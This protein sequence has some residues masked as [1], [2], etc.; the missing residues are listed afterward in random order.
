MDEDGGLPTTDE[1]LA[2][3]EKLK[4]LDDETVKIVS[5]ITGAPSAESFRE[6]FP[7]LSVEDLKQMRSLF[8]R[9]GLNDYSV[10]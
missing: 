7:L 8:R 5:S 3:S 6:G 10:L 2:L 9:M 4:E 1:L